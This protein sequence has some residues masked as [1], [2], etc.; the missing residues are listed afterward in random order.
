MM[1]VQQV[2]PFQEKLQQLDFCTSGSCDWHRR[3]V[4]I[5]QMTTIS[6]V[7]ITNTT[8]EINPVI[9]IF[10]HFLMPIQYIQDKMYTGTVKPIPKEA[11]FICLN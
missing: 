9:R 6:R 4:R 5:K 7:W 8:E 3:H 10:S 2:Q 11:L 1:E